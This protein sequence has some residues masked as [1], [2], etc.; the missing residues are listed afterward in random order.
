MNKLLVMAL[1]CGSIFLLTACASSAS[2]QEL[3]GGIWLLTELNGAEPIAGTTLTAE[4]DQD[5]RVGGSSGC[6]SYNTT[7]VVDG[8]ELTFGEQVASTMMA[9]PDP[10]MRQ[11]GEF[12]QA[13]VDTATY[14]IKDDELIL[15]DSS[16]NEVA[17]FEVIDQSLGGSSWQVIS[18][19][20]GKEAVVSVII[21]TEI[22]ANF[23]EDGTMTGNAGCNNYSTKYET[24][25]DKISI[26]TAEFTEM[27]C[28][29][30]EGIMEQEQLYLA[31]LETADTYK[32][33]GM[34][35]DM[36]TSEGSRVANFQRAL[37]P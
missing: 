28:L 31:A 35:M 1:A 15:S 37:N 33:E 20:N 8:N 22:T 5:G 34:T 18:Y 24:E 36:R 7:Y 30:P 10:I 16:G 2:S 6:N 27:G 13:L 32:I 19:N 11:E 25:G 9:C 4:F 26:G 23:G 12:H 17:R 14:E 3:T 21:G 29:E